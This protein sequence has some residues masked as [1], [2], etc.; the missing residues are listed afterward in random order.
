MVLAGNYSCINLQSTAK[1]AGNL[2]PSMEASCRK[3]PAA[4][5][6]KCKT[7]PED[8]TCPNCALCTVDALS[9]LGRPGNET[10]ARVCLRVC[11]SVVAIALP[12][13]GASQARRRKTR[14]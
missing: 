2:L 1:H 11:F 4:R 7:P 9:R 10:S 8:Y 3:G 12:F 5:E 6:K 13:S 14:C